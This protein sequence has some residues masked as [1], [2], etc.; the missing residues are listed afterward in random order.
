MS[1]L[2]VLESNRIRHLA[3]MGLI[4]SSS[5]GPAIESGTFWIGELCEHHDAD[6]W[7]E[8]EQK[9]PTAEVGIMQPANGDCNAR[10]EYCNDEQKVEDAEEVKPFAARRGSC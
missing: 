9:V 5:S 3:W 10:Q 4:G 7:N 6:Y 1:R 8:S 2:V